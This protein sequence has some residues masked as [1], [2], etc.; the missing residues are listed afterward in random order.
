[1]LQGKQSKEGEHMRFPSQIFLELQ[2]GPLEPEVVCKYLVTLSELFHEASSC[3]ADLFQPLLK[4]LLLLQPGPLEVTPDAV[5]AR[6]PV[7][8]LHDL[9]LMSCITSE[10]GC[11][12]RGC[13]LEISAWKG[14]CMD[15][16][17]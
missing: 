8:F 15:G 2:K 9:S 4:L 3:S 13:W 10:H 7:L 14:V 12:Q 11:F 17:V 6:A 16:W 1:M 5:S